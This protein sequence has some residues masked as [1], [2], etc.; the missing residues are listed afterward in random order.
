[1]VTTSILPFSKDLLSSGE[2]KFFFQF[3]ACFHL[4]LELD[5]E[6]GNPYVRYCVL[7]VC[8]FAGSFVYV[9]TD[10]PT[11]ENEEDRFVR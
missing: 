3:S 1:M 2:S 7:P 9:R 11:Q 8:V 6:R 5:V 10:L 4:R